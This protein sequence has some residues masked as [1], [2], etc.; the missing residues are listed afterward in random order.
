[1]I[2]FLAPT[3]FGQTI[4]FAHR[5]EGKLRQARALTDMPESEAIAWSAILA[6][7]AR[8]SRLRS[9]ED[10]LDAWL[11]NLREGLSPALAAAALVESM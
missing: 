9:A 8:S 1:M 2:S 7:M 6:G 3:A 10:F 4:A 5:M 11:Q